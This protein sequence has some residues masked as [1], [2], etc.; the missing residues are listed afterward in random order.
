MGAIKYIR[1]KKGSATAAKEYTGDGT[2]QRIV[3]LGAAEG[4]YG[5][6]MKIIPHLKPGSDTAYLVTLYAAPHHVAAFARYLDSYGE[7]H[8]KSAEHDEVLRPGVCYLNSGANYMTLHQ[9]RREPVLHVSPAPFVSRKGSIDM[10]FFSIADVMQ[11]HCMGVLL[12]GCGNDGVEG[13]EEIVRVG[14]NSMVQEPT[15][16]ICGEMINRAIRRVDIAH[17][18]NDARIAAVLNDIQT[19]N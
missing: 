8:V 6:L 11:S 19:V 1:R 14:G 15:T 5:A 2:A 18:E 13:L 10:M 3:A 16:A 9:Y 7:L 12:S 4:G 17:I